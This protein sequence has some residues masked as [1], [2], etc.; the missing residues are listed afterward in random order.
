MLFCGVRSSSNLP[1]YQ[2]AATTTTTGSLAAT[3]PTN[4]V[5]RT[6][7]SWSLR[8]P[9]DTSLCEPGLVEL[10]AAPVAGWLAGH[11]PVHSWTQ[12]SSSSLE[13]GP[14]VP[15]EPHSLG[16][17]DVVIRMY[18]VYHE[19][20]LLTALAQSEVILHLRAILR[21]AIPSRDRTRSKLEQGLKFIPKHLRRR[22]SSW[23][24]LRECPQP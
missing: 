13:P 7:P 1:A 14:V 9:P 22:F 3:Q 16:A 23:S 4:S 12:S 24:K 6:K 8:L 20:R 2:A 5:G 19:Q 10:R 11:S 18:S 17:A 15:G 21:K